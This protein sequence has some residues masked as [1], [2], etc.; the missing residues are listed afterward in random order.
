ME[1]FMSIQERIAAGGAGEGFPIRRE[2]EAAQGP[3][4]VI[5][6]V[7]RRAIFTEGN[8]AET[9]ID[10]RISVPT[11][12]RFL[13]EAST[14]NFV[15]FCDILFQNAQLGSDKVPINEQDAL[16]QYARIVQERRAT[17]VMQYAL[18]V[19]CLLR[20]FKKWLFWLLKEAI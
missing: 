18:D 20:K 14:K 1:F 15:E 12:E 9:P 4:A 13:E 19:E 5:D 10:T 3:D 7:V 2:L 6:R 8:H 16:E 17:A 11:R